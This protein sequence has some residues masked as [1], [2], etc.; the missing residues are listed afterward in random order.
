MAI[1]WSSLSPEP[2]TR[3]D[4]PAAGRLAVPG[5]RVAIPGRRV[6]VP[7]RRAAVPGRRAAVPGRRPSLPDHT[8]HRT[9]A[10]TTATM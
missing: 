6:A 1:E 2:L 5:R 10:D 8:S 3:L 7:G 4:R 9:L